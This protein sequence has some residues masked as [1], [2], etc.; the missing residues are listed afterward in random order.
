MKRRV[1]CDPHLINHSEYSKEI[2]VVQL[3]LLQLRQHLVIHDKVNQIRRLNVSYAHD[4][5]TCYREERFE[6]VLHNR[7]RLT[8][9]QLWQVSMVG[10]DIQS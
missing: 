9:S 3:K 6:F 7:Q 10:N 4:Q 2:S 8:I 1:R 5:Q